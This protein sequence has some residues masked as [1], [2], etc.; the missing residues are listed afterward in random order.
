MPSDWHVF[1]IKLNWQL[2]R[3][4]CLRRYLEKREGLNDISKFSNVMYSFLDS[5][6]ETNGNSEI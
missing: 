2:H 1:M 6:K 5:G 3:Q 4:R